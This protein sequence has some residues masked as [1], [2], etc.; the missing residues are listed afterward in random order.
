[1]VIICKYYHLQVFS[2]GIYPDL[3]TIHWTTLHNRMPSY[4]IKKEVLVGYWNGYGAGMGLVWVWGMCMGLVWYEA[5]I[6]IGLV[7]YGAD[8][9]MV[10]VWE[11]DW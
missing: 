11:W 2:S 5:G 4:V 9:G 10:L 8:I 3:E 1:M 6:G 7:W